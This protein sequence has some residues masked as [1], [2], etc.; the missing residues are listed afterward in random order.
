MP[1][2]SLLLSRMEAEGLVR[3][4]RDRPKRSAVSVRRTASGRRLHERS[5]R[6][7]EAADAELARAP[8]PAD[9]VALGRVTRALARL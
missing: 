3:R 2:M 4:S 6:A 5:R 7:R 1:A 8:R 9:V